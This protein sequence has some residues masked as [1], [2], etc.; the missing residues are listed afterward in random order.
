MRWQSGAKLRLCSPFV[1]NPSIIEPLIGV[2][3]LLEG[4]FRLAI[5]IRRATGEL[6]SKGKPKQP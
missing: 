4:R 1:K 2:V 6:I 5:T 3:E